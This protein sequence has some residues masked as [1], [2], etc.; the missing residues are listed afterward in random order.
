LQVE[1][2]MI[3]KILML[4]EAKGWDQGEL[5]S[6]AGLA[7]GRISKWKA[8]Q[9]E[10][11]ASQTL[12]IARLLNVSMEFLADD[13]MSTPAPPP[14]ASLAD[15]ERTIVELYRDL[16]IGKREAVKRLATPLLPGSVRDQTSL[17]AAEL[18]ESSRPTRG[19]DAER[20]G[21]VPPK[22]SPVPEVFIGERNNL[23]PGEELPRPRGDV[24]PTPKTRRRRRE[25]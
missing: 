9:G 13:R 18:R 10:P 24:P 23:P 1:A 3:D 19:R 8:D 17:L 22:P 16:E 20:E 11:T 2:M 14:S 15:D 4:A 21:G 7:R 12:R 25:G 6:R 5:E